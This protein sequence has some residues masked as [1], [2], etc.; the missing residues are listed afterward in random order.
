MHLSQ[1][2][3]DFLFPAILCV[4]VLLCA[5]PNDERAMLCLE[6]LCLYSLTI[7]GPAS[8]IDKRNKSM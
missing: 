6:V 2:E 8:C 7:K 1:N 5:V 4:C 3:C